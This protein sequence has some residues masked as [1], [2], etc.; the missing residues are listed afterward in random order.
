MITSRCQARECIF[1]HVE[2]KIEMRADLLSLSETV[3]YPE[4]NPRD[5]AFLDETIRNFTSVTS[6]D[7][8]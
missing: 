5:F 8:I 6:Q 2:R 3:L 1:E 4:R 7:I